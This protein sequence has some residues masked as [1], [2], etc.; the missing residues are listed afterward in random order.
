MLTWSDDQ[1]RRWREPFEPLRPP[2]LDGKRGV[3]RSVYPTPLG[4]DEVLV[5][6]LWVDAS[7]P[8]LPF[9]NEKNDGLLESR[10]F[11]S[12]STDGGESWSEPALM[13]VNP[14][15]MWTPPTGPALLLPDGTWAAQ[16]ELNK[17]FDDGTPWRH[18]S[19]LM[20]SRDRGR[21]WPL[22]SVA[23]NDPSNRMFYWDQ[24]PGVLADGS[25]LD[26]FWTYDNKAAVYRNIHARRSADGGRTW[27]ALW[28]T[29]VPGQPAQPVTLADGRIGLVYVDR[30]AAPLIKMRASADGGASFPA[31]TELVLYGGEG[32][33]TERKGAMRDAWA[34]MGRFSIGLPATAPLAGGDVLVV[35][36]AGPETDVT[37]VEWV[38]I[39][40]G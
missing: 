2:V 29:G 5:T 10:L 21:T 19:I 12:V 3:F 33:Q 25:I 16:F 1:G 32:T 20:F 24:R 30:T 31:E 23:G 28:D 15:Q 11:H 8:S 38:R 27:S 6:L 35:Y 7:D 36:Y 18:S 9:F 40:T 17:H 34:E 22:L 4:G 37:D 39:S 26:A 13:D 14:I